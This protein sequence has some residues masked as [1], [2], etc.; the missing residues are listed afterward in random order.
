MFNRGPIFITRAIA[1]LTL[2]LL[3]SMVLVRVW[4]MKRRGMRAMHFG[5]TDKKDFLIV[6][7]VKE[8]S[9]NCKITVSRVNFH[10]GGRSSR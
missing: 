4:I 3:V 6:R 2:V 5:Q 8:D 9:Y 10:R 1:A 7:C